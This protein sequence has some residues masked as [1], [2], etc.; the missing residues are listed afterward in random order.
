MQS[1]DLSV[2]GSVSAYVGVVVPGVSIQSQPACAST[3]TGGDGYVYG[4]SHT[5]VSNVTAG[6]YS[7]TYSSKLK[8]A[9][10]AQAVNTGSITLNTLATPTT[11]DSW[12]GVV[13]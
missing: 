8:S 11:I 1:Y 9:N 12:A 3:T 13:E 6:A 2:G 4:A 5:T 7:L 10:G